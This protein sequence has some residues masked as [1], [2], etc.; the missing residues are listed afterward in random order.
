[1][2]QILDSDESWIYRVYADTSENGYAWRG[3]NGDSTVP[4]DFWNFKGWG[5]MHGNSLKKELLIHCRNL[6][7][8]SFSIRSILLEEDLIFILK[9]HLPDLFQEILFPFSVSLLNAPLYDGL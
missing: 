4:S 7:Y 9:V 8:G 3:V 5:K 1:L 2:V 6:N